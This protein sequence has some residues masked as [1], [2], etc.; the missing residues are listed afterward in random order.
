MAAGRPDYTSQALIKGNCSGVG[1][2]TVAV[3]AAGN[4]L[5]VLK[6]DYAGSLKT[7]A[8]DDQGR[9]LAVLTDPEDV[10]GNPHYMGAAE[11]A[12]RLGSPASGDRRGQVIFMDPGGVNAA[13]YGHTSSGADSAF[14]EY[15]N[16]ASIQ[17]LCYRLLAGPAEDDFIS[18]SKY[19]PYET[20]AGVGLELLL[21]RDTKV[22]TF[23]M[24]MI[25]QDGVNVTQGGIQVDV[26]AGKV[27][28]YDSTGTWTDLVTIVAGSSLSSPILLK[29][30][31]DPT[32]GKYL[33]ARVD[34][35]RTDMSAL[36]L[37][38]TATATA[39]LVYTNLV[40]KCATSGTTT[41]YLNNLIITGAEE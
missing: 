19:V 37:Q 11:L 9:M 27:K 18:L 31:M 5:G 1:I 21:A 40:L 17:P 36:A 2:L 34:N 39:K 14:A 24:S 7:L 35:T 20:P 33:D 28:Y 29:V 22:K 41:A 8:V 32:T 4:I 25:I 16:G 26:V 15:G 3:D 30:R 10:F 6:G 23:S 38:V 13:Q 12:A